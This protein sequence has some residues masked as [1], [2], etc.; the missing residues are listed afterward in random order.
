M[1]II[2]KI[3]RHMIWRGVLLILFSPEVFGVFLGRAVFFLG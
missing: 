3:P 2:N 1:I